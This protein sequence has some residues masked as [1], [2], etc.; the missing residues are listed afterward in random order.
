MM[1]SDSGC[2][3]EL[4]FK[5][6]WVVSGRLFRIDPYFIFFLLSY[7]YHGIK[8]VVESLC[9]PFLHLHFEYENERCLVV[10]M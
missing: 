6:R 3:L 2:A 7:G 10:L 5:R 9:M 1:T 4:E 8:K